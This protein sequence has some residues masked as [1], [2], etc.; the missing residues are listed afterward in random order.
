ML[1]RC[2]LAELLKE[3]KPNDELIHK[4]F[5]QIIEAV[6]VLHRLDIIHSDL[7]LAQILVD[8]EDNIRLSDFNASQYPNNVALG[9][10]K[11]TNCLP[12]DY[13]ALNTV[14]S[15]LFVLGSTLYEL[16]TGHP[17]YE[18]LYAD[19]WR[20]PT[21]DDDQL[22]A[23]IRRKHI[24]DYRAEQQYKQGDFPDVS[25]VFGGGIILGLWNGTIISANDALTLYYA[26]LS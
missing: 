14:S 16:T 19:L 15:D 7:R 18:E 11:A 25:Q 13:A 22:R 1:A 9:Y 21:D 6:A 10:E 24:A 4:C 3:G 12:R 17:P 23:E 20:G 5:G 8:G 26:D 2:D